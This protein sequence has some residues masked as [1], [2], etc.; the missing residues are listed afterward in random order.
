MNTLAFLDKAVQLSQFWHRFLAE[1]TAGF[2]CG[3]LCNLVSQDG[4]ILW[5]RC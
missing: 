5:M 4:Y 1:L 2:L 3:N